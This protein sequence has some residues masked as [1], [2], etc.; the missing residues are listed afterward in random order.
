[1]DRLHQFSCL[2][3]RSDLI[4]SCRRVQ[5]ILSLLVHYINPPVV[6]RTAIIHWLRRYPGVAVSE[7]RQHFLLCFE[8]HV[9]V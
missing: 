1:M 3:F 2:F 7:H 4:Q 6:K 5:N 9:N 8:H